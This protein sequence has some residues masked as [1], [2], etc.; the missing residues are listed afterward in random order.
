MDIACP[1]CLATYEIDVATLSPSGRKVRCAACGEIWRV[2]APA[3]PEP[4]NADLSVAALSEAAASADPAETEPAKTESAAIDHPA[5]DRAEI[6]R[7]EID[8]P[9]MDRAGAAPAAS[10]PTDVAAPDPDQPDAPPPT[11]RKRR[12]PWSADAGAG[13]ARPPVWRRIANSRIA[14]WRIAACAAALVVVAGG[15]HQRER[16]VRAMPQSARLYAAVGLPV[17]LRGIDIRNV[18]S[19]IAKDGEESVLVV[20][21]DLVN[22]AGRPV[23]VPRLHFALLAAD[24]RQIYVWSAQADRAALQPGETLNFR[25]RLA[26]PP[27][28]A[29]DVSVRFLNRSDI[30]AGIK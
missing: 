5:L 8:H 24:G 16:V 17:N 28:E 14:D 19:R 7:A 21:G 18:R 11:A 10:D 22:V 6:D 2:V 27:P 1:K 20:D 30:T 12:A 3:S 9:A 15:L 25:R 29:R 13:R 26:A 4:A 23:D